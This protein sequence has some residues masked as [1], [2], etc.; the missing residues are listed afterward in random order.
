[1]ENI[2]YDALEKIGYKGYLL[3]KDAPE[4]VLQFG[5]GN[6][7]R[8]FVD[9]FFDMGNEATGWNGKVVMVQPINGAFGFADG[10]NAQ[11]D[12]Y[13]VLVRGKENGNTVD[14]SRVISACSRCL[15]PYRE[16]DYRAMMEV[17]VSDDLEI[18]V[19]NTTE[20]GITYDPSCKADDM[21]PASFPAKLAQVLHTRWAAGKP[22]V[23]VLACEAHRSQ[24]R[25]VAAHHEPVCERLGLGGRVCA[26]DGQ[27]LHRLHH[28]RRHHRAGPYPRR[29]RG[30][31]G[32]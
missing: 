14:E 29:I 19:S 22:G 6:F 1:M 4:K 9:R 21:P 25:G 32:G 16:D 24:R 5:E 31:R 23:I 15:N 3:P 17:A 18:I 10:I 2:S 7:L 8:A 26:V 27:R 13:T 28:A 12:L 30:R 20:A 11:D